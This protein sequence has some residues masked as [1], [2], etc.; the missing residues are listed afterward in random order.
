M[1]DPKDD[2]A[3]YL[4]GELT[5]AEMHALEKKALEDPFISDALE[6]VSGLGAGNFEADLKVLQGKLD[7]RIDAKRG[8]VAS[9]WVWPMRIAAGLALIAVATF[10]VVR[11]TG[12]TPQERLAENK[13]PAPLPEKKD[14][15]ATPAPTDTAQEIS[16]DFLSLA[17][18]E[19]PAAIASAKEPALKASAEESLSSVS[20]P[21]TASELGKDEAEDVGEASEDRESNAQIA[22][23]DKAKI[24]TSVPVEARQ[25][26][27]IAAPK[28]SVSTDTRRARA[29]DQIA[30]G[31]AAV[32]SS[33]EERPSKII[34]G[35]V[36]S[37]DGSALPGVNVVIKGTNEGTVTDAQG[38]Y[39]LSINTIAPTLVYSFIGYTDAEVDADKRNEINIQLKEDAAQLSEVVVTGYSSGEAD[40]SS[41]SNL[42]FAGP[43]G[44]RRAYE[45]YLET[46][47]HYPKAAQENNI[48]GRVTV[49]FTVET[50]GELADFKVLRGIG[51][52]CDEEVVRLIKE[53]P[54]WTPTMRNKNAVRDLVKVRMKFALPKK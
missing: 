19:E 42:E 21:P 45:H 50:T 11:L 37:D 3:R 6:G 23:E 49:Q 43:E 28:K 44:G 1:G 47:L 12:D 17:K 25:A 26:E 15:M 35:Q 54:G 38:N 13:Q 2:I 22:D 32:T 29:L 24:A 31:A 9:L 7:Q 48:E 20:Q 18:P 41:L 8:R 39:Q 53:G 14:E 10:I 33:A 5:P 4:R 30:A 16:K 52:G 46:N 34:R 27:T 36:K 40:N 51:Y